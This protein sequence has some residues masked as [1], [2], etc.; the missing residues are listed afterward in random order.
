[1]RLLPQV[2]SALWSTLRESSFSFYTSTSSWGQKLKNARFM[3]EREPHEKSQRRREHPRKIWNKFAP[4]YL[5]EH[6]FDDLCLGQPDSFFLWSRQTNIYYD[7]E[8]SLERLLCK[9]FLFAMIST[10]ET[11][12]VYFILTWNRTTKLLYCD[13]I[14]YYIIYC[15][16]PMRETLS[17]NPEGEGQIQYSSHV[18]GLFMLHFLNFVVHFAVLNERVRGRVC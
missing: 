6:S 15:D 11:I 10:L 8:Q 3:R 17:R 5:F 16:I 4:L 2:L 12:Y 13:I 18:P 9:Q 14:L 7:P 1:M